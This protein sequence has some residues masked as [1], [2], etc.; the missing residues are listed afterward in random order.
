MQNSAQPGHTL[1]LLHSGW[2]LKLPK[3]DRDER[4]KKQSIFKYLPFPSPCCHNIF[5]LLLVLIP[6]FLR[7]RIFSSAYSSTLCRLS[8]SRVTSPALEK[9]LISIKDFLAEAQFLMKFSQPKDSPV[10]HNLHII[11]RFF[12]FVSLP[13]AAI[14]NLPFF[15]SMFRT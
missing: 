7:F 9:F 12:F 2:A 11:F 15:G 3:D 5:I 1:L 10:A 6:C 14:F 4:K 8:F 13:A